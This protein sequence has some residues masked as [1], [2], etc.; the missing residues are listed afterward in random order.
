MFGSKSIAIGFFG[1][2]SL[3][4]DL[5]QSYEMKPDPRLM[6]E[7]S[8]LDKN[9]PRHDVKIIK[10]EAEAIITINFYEMKSLLASI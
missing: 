3:A 2:R 1:I 5:S 4:L 7:Y 6:G 8:Q 10:E 9:G